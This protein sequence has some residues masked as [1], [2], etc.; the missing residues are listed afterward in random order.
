[1]KVLLQDD[2]SDGRRGVWPVEENS[3]EKE[4]RN[5]NNI[6]HDYVECVVVA[7]VRHRFRSD[8]LVRGRRE[9]RVRPVF[10]PVYSSPVPLERQPRTVLH[11][12]AGRTAKTIRSGC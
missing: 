8:G 12:P 1:M 7:N 6:P 11:A 2:E 10:V 5:K 9:G 4:G 3:E